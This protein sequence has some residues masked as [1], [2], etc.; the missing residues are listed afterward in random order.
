MK[1][2]GLLLFVLL[3]LISPCFGQANQDSGVRFSSLSGEVSVRPNADDDDSYEFAEMDMVLNNNDRIRTIEKSS[4]ILSFAD[5]STF[6]LKEES[7]IVL[8]VGDEK[9]SKVNLIAGKIWVNVKKMV[10][11]GNMDIEMNQAVAGIK[12]TNITCSTNA[13]EDRIQVLRGVAEVLIRESRQ[14][15]TVKEGEELIV[16]RGSEPQKIEIDVIEQ[17][18]EWEEAVSKMGEMLELGELPDV[19]RQIMDSEASEF[20]KISNT[21]QHLSSHEVAK[22]EEVLGLK[23]DAERFVGVILEDSLILASARRKVAEALADPATTSATKA[24]LG[25]LSK[26]I[27][28]AAAR[29][30]T[31]QTELAKIMRY[32]FKLSKA[33]EGVAIEVDMLNT[34]LAQLVTEIDVIRAQVAANPTGMSQEWFV[35]SL[36]VCNLTITKLDELA[37]KVDDLLSGHSTEKALQALLKNIA[38]QQKAVATLMR[39]LKVIEIDSAKLIELSQIDDVLSDQL[40]SLQSE[41]DA[42]SSLHGTTATDKERRLTSSIRIMSSYARTRR[43]YVNAQRL[44]D[45][46]MR[47]TAGSKFKTS[48]Q[49]EV[50]NLWQ[51]IS[52]RFQQLGIVAQEL[53]SNIKD[54]ENQLNTLL[55]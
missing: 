38:S 19:L 29:Q 32:K 46:T 22:E 5:L 31:L 10:V 50:E 25:T 9:N 11:D 47:A 15:I 27:A 51:N 17:Q 42:Y 3:I 14:T 1:R 43:L 45:S 33:G 21:F 40:V 6:V 48:E 54:L 30:Q 49:E 35:E 53:E 23:K 36:N 12:G 4:A 13:S 41:I 55:K 7:V 20:A 28:D 24:S 26:T 34:E 44:Y 37:R 16:K 18:K 39:S 52:D 2:I 8:D